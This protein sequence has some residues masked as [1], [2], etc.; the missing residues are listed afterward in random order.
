MRSARPWK[1]ASNGNWYVCFNG[2]QRNLGADEEKAFEK[3]RR[4]AQCGA[5]GDFTVRQIVQSYWKWA[6]ANLAEATLTRRKP[7]L[8]SFSRAMRPTLKADALRAMHVQDWID[9]KFKQK[10]AVK[11]GKRGERKVSDKPLS[12]TTIADYITIIKGVMN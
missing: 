4:M 5:T 12:P 3:F 7:I 10:V 6:K 1:R 8:E 11:G 9:N 2:K